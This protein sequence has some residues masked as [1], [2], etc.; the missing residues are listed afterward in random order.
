MWTRIPSPYKY[1]KPGDNYSAF[2]RRLRK[3]QAFAILFA[4]KPFACSHK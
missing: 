4:D 3:F 1:V 2:D